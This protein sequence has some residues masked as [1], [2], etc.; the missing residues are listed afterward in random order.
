[1]YLSWTLS[2]I[3]PYLLCLV[4]GF[5][6]SYFLHKS[7]YKLKVLSYLIWLVPFG[8]YFAFNPI[9][10]G[11]FSN[12]YSIIYNKELPTSIASGELVVITIPGCPFCFESIAT[13]KELKIR[14]PKLKITFLVCSSDK[15]TVLPY[16]TEINHAFNIQTTDKPKEWAN[17]AQGKFP[18][19]LFRKKEKIQVW[20][21]DSFGCIAKDEVDDR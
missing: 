4:G 14:N 6:F 9:Y 7:K 21:N 19:F 3:F 10:E 15:K 13:L 8:I 12:N 16:T 18:S 17:I 11:D 2:K 20:S 1:M 5:L